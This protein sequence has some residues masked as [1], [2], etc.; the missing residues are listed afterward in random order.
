MKL[1]FSM[2]TARVRKFMVNAEKKDNN[3]VRQDQYSMMS[4]C[5]CFV[6]EFTVTH[7]AAVIFL[8]SRSRSE[9]RSRSW[10][11]YSWLW[12]GTNRPYRA[13]TGFLLV[14]LLLLLHQRVLLPRQ[15]AHPTCQTVTLL[16]DFRVKKKSSIPEMSSILSGTVAKGLRVVLRSTLSIS[17]SSSGV[18]VGTVGGLSFQGRAS[19]ST[20]L[21][22]TSPKA[23]TSSRTV[24]IGTHLTQQHRFFSEGGKSGVMTI[25]EELNKQAQ[26]LREEGK[27]TEAL[28][29]YH[30][31]AQGLQEEGDS[32][33][34]GYVYI[35]I[36]LCF[37][38]T[39]TN[40]PPLLLLL[41][42]LL[43]PTTTT[44]N[45]A[46]PWETSQCVTSR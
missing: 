44:T 23:W 42:L 30:E 43:P 34:L 27:P 46:T 6:D 37:S 14:L 21:G 33:N 4:V 8:C 41:L 25:L 36:G 7:N 1:S 2:S 45:A 40:T 3:I 5:V 38:H 12:D 18:N 39:H 10:M 22:R 11:D 15:K 32:I 9:I 17:P 35:Y 20:L 16:S 19:Y 26:T 29:L 31:I 28:P 24:G 13:Y